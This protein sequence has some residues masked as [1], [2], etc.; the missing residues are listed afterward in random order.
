MLKDI[1]SVTQKKDGNSRPIEV[2][3]WDQKV[4][5]NNT[6]NATS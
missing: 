2:L 4:Q 6:L 1:L 5:T 3:T